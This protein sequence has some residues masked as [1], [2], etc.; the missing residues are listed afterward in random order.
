MARA[1]SDL[2]PP[3]NSGSTPRGRGRPSHLTPACAESIV[4]DLRA[5]ISIR[6]AAA[7]AS[8]GQTHDH[9]LARTGRT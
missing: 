8:G 7:H 1:H 3:A 4:A 5:G 6:K 9:H 2:D